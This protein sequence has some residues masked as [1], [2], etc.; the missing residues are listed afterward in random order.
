MSLEWPK[1]QSRLHEAEP[2]AVPVVEP[3]RAEGEIRPRLDPGVGAD[4]AV[5]DRPGAGHEL[6]RRSGRVV[7]G[8]GVVQ[9]RLVR[10]REQRPEVLGADPAREEVV[11]VGREAHHRQDLAGLG[12]HR[13]HDAALDA[14]FLHAPLERLLGV[15]LLLGVDRQA[16]RAAG[17]CVVDRLED[18]ERPAGCVLFD[19][20]GAIH[21]AERFLVVRL[22]AGLAHQ[23]VGQVALRLQ[24]LDLLGGHGPRVA[25]ELREQRALGVLAACLDGDLDTG[26]LEAGLGDQARRLLRDVLGDPDSVESRSRVA[27]DRHVDVDDRFPGQRGQPGDDLVA[28]VLRQVGGPDLDRERRD[29][30]DEHGTRSV[31]DQASRGRDGLQRRPVALGERRELATVDDLEVEQ[32][33]GQRAEGDDD[34]EPEDQEPG[35]RARAGLTAVQVAVAHQSTRSSSTYR[36]W[37]AMASGPTR[38]AITAS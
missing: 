17:L 12:V 15:L 19:A 33:G 32:T 22:E 24:R 38:T 4:L 25:E 6:V 8:D 23:V 37:R 16:E 7:G 29:V 20:L 9:E 35:Q 21:A 31:V 13:D 3:R 2:A 34:R 36:S 1:P 18:L 11:V 27:V 30:R 5:G 26:Q 10:V 28:T 14:G